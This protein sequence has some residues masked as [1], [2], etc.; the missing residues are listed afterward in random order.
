M[1]ISFGNHN[2]WWPP[3]HGV[4]L[5]LSEANHRSTKISL[6]QTSNG[7]LNLIQR[8]FTDLPAIPSFG[9]KKFQ[10]L[11]QHNFI[12]NHQSWRTEN[13]ITNTHIIWAISNWN[14]EIFF[15]IK[16]TTNKTVVHLKFRFWICQIHFWK[17]DL[18]KNS[19]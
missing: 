17:F 8:N 14:W 16:S 18:T 6:F 13:G 3:T 19:G 5:K 4:W 11:L 7:I 2:K 10:S 12:I 15:V 9:E 1:D